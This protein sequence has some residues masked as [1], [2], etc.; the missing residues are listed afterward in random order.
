M[1]SVTV[2]NVLRQR[3]L[4]DVD[5]RNPAA[6]LSSL[7]ERF[8]MDSHNGMYFTMWYG[9]YR[10]GDRTLTFDSAGHHPA[11]LVAPERQESQPLGA[12]ALMIGAM[13]ASDY[14]VQQTTVPTGS[15]LYLFSDGV[16]EF[17]TKDEKQWSLTDFLP[18]LLEQPHPGT[19]EA[20]RL[21]QVVTQA[22]RPGPLDDDFSLVVL[23]FV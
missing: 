22:A 12:P 9:V 11:F 18:L 19:S 6:V 1:H 14:Q 8:Q 2:L 7:N 5:F 10:P 13:P 20:E 16:V 15:A 21:Y 3:A 4:P 23:T 17:E